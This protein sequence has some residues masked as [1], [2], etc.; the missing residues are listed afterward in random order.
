MCLSQR[1]ARKLA[2]KLLRQADKAEDQ[3]K[4]NQ[5]ARARIKRRRPIG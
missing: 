3:G 4:L 5:A 1:H 2:I